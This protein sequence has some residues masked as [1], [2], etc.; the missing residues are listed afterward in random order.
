MTNQRGVQGHPALCRR[1]VRRRHH[2]NRGE[3]G[4]KGAELG[5]HLLK[6]RIGS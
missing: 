2:L 6:K 3:E 1:R 5:K 4:R